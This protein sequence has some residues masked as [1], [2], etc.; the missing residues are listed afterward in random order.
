MA[1][2]PNL[3]EVRA[4]IRRLLDDGVEAA[5]VHDIFIGASAANA[6]AYLRAQ[7]E[8]A[9]VPRMATEGGIT[10]RSGARSAGGRRSISG[11]KEYLEGAPC[12]A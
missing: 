6:N 2:T 3:D 4:G 11:F 5:R 8:Y 12:C 1:S 9:S 10:F 7:S